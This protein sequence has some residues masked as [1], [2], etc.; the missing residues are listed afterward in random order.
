MEKMTYVKALEIAIESV[1]DDAV[2]EKLEALK[3]SIAKKNSGAK[4][5]TAQQ[6]AN[7]EYKVAIYDFLCEDGTALSI[8]EIGKNCEA[9]AELSS[10]RLTA[11]VHQLK[12]D[13]KVER[14]EEKR[15]AYFKAIC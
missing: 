8:S 13:G 7:A 11:L 2:I 10:Q 1:A 4:K 9:V 15:K 3:A 5:P 14:I 6:N 12:A